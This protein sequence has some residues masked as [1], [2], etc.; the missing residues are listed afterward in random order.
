MSREFKPF[1]KT[2]VQTPFGAVTVTATDANHVHVSAAWGENTAPIKVNG[3]EY[4]LT[5]HL[6]GP[7]WTPKDHQ[8]VSI[9]RAEW[10][11]KVY[12]YSVAALKKVRAG[13]PQVLSEWAQTAEG[14]AIL[15]EAQVAKASNALRSVE[16]K[17]VE[18]RQAVLDLEAERV[19]LDAALAAAHDRS[20]AVAW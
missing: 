3:V 8:S 19:S 12:D 13:L 7:D 11:G 18:A 6:Y 17:L 20:Q 9:D 2:T 10:R 5:A 4:K 15:A 14:A 1:P 16:D